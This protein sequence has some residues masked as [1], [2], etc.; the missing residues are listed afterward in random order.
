MNPSPRLRSALHTATTAL[1]NKLT[2]DGHWVGVL[3]SSSLST[4]TAVI[5]LAQLRKQDETST[6]AGLLRDGVAWLVAHQNPDGGWGDTVRSRSNISTTA[7]C[8]AALGAAEADALYPESVLRVRSWL[9][10]ACGASGPGWERILA[11]AI[12]NRYGK[13]RTF[14]VPILMACTLSG[15]LGEAGWAEVPALPFELAA[16]PHQFF[17]IMQMPVVS[18]AL[19]ALIAI[20]QVI[21]H[22]APSRNPLL[23]GIRN[24]LRAKTLRVLGTLQPPNGGFLEATPLT[25]FVL[26]SLAAMGEGA[27]PVGRLATAF[28]RGSVRADGSWPIDTN[29]AT[30]VSTLSVQALSWQLDVLSYEQRYDLREWLLGQQYRVEHPY[31]HAAPGGWAWTNLPGGVPDGDDTPGALLALLALGPVDGPV[32][33]SGELGT[34]WLLGLQNRD[35]GIPTFCR[36]WGALPFD[37]SSPD[38]TAHTLRAW[39]AWLPQWTGAFRQKVEAAIRRGVTFLERVQC[40]GGGWEPL[41]FGNE[42]A[43]NEANLTYGT[44]RVLLALREIRD[45]GFVVPEMMLRNAES[46]LVGLQ[47]KDGGWGG[48][49][50][51]GMVASVEETGLAVEALAGSACTGAAD[52]GVEWLLGRVES[53]LWKEPAPIGFYFAKLWYFEELYPLIHT[54]GALGA[55]AKFEV[56]ASSPDQLTAINR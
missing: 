19:P 26:M 29:L 24:L 39:S 43:S 23:R 54:V 5:A 32:R 40:R 45:R 37:R 9:E 13:D 12:R 27:G 30:W 1:L 46:V 35:G 53:G 51:A 8:W 7:L 3:S 50:G 56:G 16:F 36:G 28:L 11:E 52:R 15:R 21:H 38:L 34:L 17:G 22:F 18:Y 25:S 47:L 33:V 6:D 48:N 55:A 49:T 14:S 2:L 41:W 20:G 44:S 42:H 31:T 4:A 10:Q